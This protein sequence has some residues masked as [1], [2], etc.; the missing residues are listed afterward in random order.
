MLLKK[1]EKLSILAFALLVL[2]AVA[3]YS[4]S[5]CRNLEY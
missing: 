1:K 3:P 5:G 4:V 2:F